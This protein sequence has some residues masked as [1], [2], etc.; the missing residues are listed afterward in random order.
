MTDARSRFPWLLTVLCGLLFAGLLALGVWQVQR[1]QWKQGLIAAAAAAASQPPAPV[2]GVLAGARPE[3]RKVKLTC[4]GF[5]TAPW[6]ELQSIHDGQAGVRLISACRDPQLDR[7]L[8]VDRGFVAD[9]VSARPPRAPSDQSFRLI[10]EIRATPEP[11]PMALAAQ[12]DRYFARD[13]AAMARAL[14]VEGPVSPWTA[15]ALESTNP[16]WRALQPSAP[17]AAFSNNHLGY[18]LTWFGLALALAGFYIALL[19][20]RASGLSR[21]DREPS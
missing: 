5:A 10:A 12:D 16:D 14:G 21:G 17:P 11:G 1:L 2:A 4:P 13:N 7:V 20:R 19:R 18:A 6:V 15:F 8:L 9:T 3:F